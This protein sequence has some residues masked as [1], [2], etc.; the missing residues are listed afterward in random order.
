MTARKNRLTHYAL[1]AVF[2]LLLAGSPMAA[3]V[4][5]KLT[6]PAGATLLG[7][8]P[9]KGVQ[10]YACAPHGT[11]NEWTFKAPEA[12]LVDAKGAVFAKHYAGPTWEAADGSKIVG[13][14][15]EMAPAPTEGAIPWLLLSATSSGNGVLS[16]ARFVQRIETAGGVG[17]KGP[18]PDQGAEQRV[19]YAAT[20]VIYK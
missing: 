19:P 16:S 20:Y 9:A 5:P 2:A 10:I 3:E 13:K 11:A 7:A 12:E 8:Y 14:V 17:P 15:M 1:F 6:P 4:P 18:C